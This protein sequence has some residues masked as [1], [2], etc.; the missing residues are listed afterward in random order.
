MALH[1]YM[2]GFPSINV[3]IASRPQD[4]VV[5]RITQVMM[6]WLVMAG[7]ILALVPLH[8]LLALHLGGGRCWA[9]GP[10]G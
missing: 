10:L 5:L 6:G 3:R 8:L 7:A 9:V 4:S 1:V 2:D